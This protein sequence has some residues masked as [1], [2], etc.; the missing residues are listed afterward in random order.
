MNGKLKRNVN[1]FWDN[2]LNLFIMSVLTGLFAGVVIT[3]YNIL[4]SLGEDT[5]VKLYSLL[6]ENPAF[7][8][9]LFVG[10][11][12][13]AV[14]I[15]TAVRFGPMMRGSC[16]PQIEGA[17]R[18]IVKFKWYVTL[19]SMFAASLACVFMGYPAGA[20]GPSLELGGCCGSAASVICRRNKM[21]KR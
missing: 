20:E 7:I 19:C 21:I 8:P 9:L 10:V 5:S 15:G 3:F 16:I 1:A 6:L 2:A 11:A 17:A 4:M 13:G 18:G 14:V 12:A